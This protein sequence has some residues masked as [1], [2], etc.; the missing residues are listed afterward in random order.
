[1]IEEITRVLSP[2]GVL[3]ISGPYD[4]EDEHTAPA[5]R[6]ENMHDLFP[7]TQWE[8]ILEEDRVPFT[9]LVYDRKISTYANHTLLLRK[10]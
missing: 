8:T 5:E 4:W 9:L 10:R 2:A 6:V 3:L 1:M 7:Q